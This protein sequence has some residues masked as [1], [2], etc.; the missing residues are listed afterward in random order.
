MVDE[1]GEF[2]VFVA[3]NKFSSKVS[4]CALFRMKCG[5]ISCLRIVVSECG[6]PHVLEHDL[7]LPFGRKAIQ[8]ESELHFLC[9]CMFSTLRVIICCCV[10]MLAGSFSHRI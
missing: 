9:N 7:T 2:C 4:S 8:N 1:N 10:R 5:C 3:A 6:C